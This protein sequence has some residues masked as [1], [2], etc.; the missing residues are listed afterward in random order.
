[1]S[2]ADNENSCVGG[3]YGVGQQAAT[4]VRIANEGD[5]GG[6]VG[7]QDVG[8]PSGNITGTQY[9]LNPRTAGEHQRRD[10]TDLARPQDFEG[11]S[12]H[13]EPVEHEWLGA[14]GPV[15]APLGGDPPRLQPART[16]RA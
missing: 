3:R 10:D 14:D 1:M 12:Q 7:T 6:R 5:V 2:G 9:D 4:P 13:N 15:E 8:G 16:A 11:Q